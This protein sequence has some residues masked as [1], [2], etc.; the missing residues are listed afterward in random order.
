MAGSESSGAA[1]APLLVVRGAVATVTLNRPAH[2][3]RLERADL[4]ALLEIFRQAD[5]DRAI[6][7]LVLTAET[8]GQ[9][10][11]VFCAGYHVG[12][13]EQ[14]QPDDR[15][16]E[17]VADSLAVLRPVTVCVLNGSVYGGACDLALAC[18]LRLGLA[19]TELRVPA[20]ALGLHYYAHGLQRFVAGLG[21]QGARRL[22]LSAQPFTA[23]RLLAMGVFEE[24]AAS[25]EA[26][27]ASLQ[28]LLADLCQLAPLAVQGMKQSIN[29][30]GMGAPDLAAM[31]ERERLAN[32]SRDFAEGR[33]AFAEKRKPQFHGE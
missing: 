14:G 5:C 21:L 3:N 19:G 29:D 12:D 30:I 32:A 4:L 20:A 18:D 7:V 13:F 2:R 10:R 27:V 1:G 6:R 28:A 33:L 24:V 22:L 9:P 15:L 8:G 31:R 17:Q 16:F 26:L 23:E 25:Q 11:P